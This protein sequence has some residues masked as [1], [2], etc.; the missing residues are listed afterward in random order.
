VNERTTILSM[1]GQGSVFKIL[2]PLCEEAVSSSKIKKAAV[3][4]KRGS[5]TILVAEDD[6][7]LRKFIRITL[8]SFG[9]E[10][11]TAEDGEEAIEIFKE[12]NNRIRLVLLD[13]IMQKKNGKEVSEAIK[14]ISPGMNVLFTSGY[15]MDV[16]KIKKIM[17]MGFDFIHKPFQ[18]KDLL[19]K[20][21]EILD[22]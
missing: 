4:I 14:K 5:E 12:N 7:S 20:V 15:T 9:H 16:L 11:I 18:S 19:M 1:V 17:E 2:L 21:R 6:P 22:R 13:M 3:F 8:E 10:V